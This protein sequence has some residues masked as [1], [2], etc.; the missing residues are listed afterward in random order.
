V[1]TFGKVHITCFFSQKEMKVTENYSSERVTVA[2]VADKW[3]R[4]G[5]FNLRESLYDS[6]AV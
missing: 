3:W 4:F 6:S 2:T 1:F 5:L